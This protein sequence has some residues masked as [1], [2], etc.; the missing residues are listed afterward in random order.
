MLRFLLLFMCLLICTV[1]SAQSY[2]WQWAYGTYGMS[3][4]NDVL[5]HPSNGCYVVGDISDTLLYSGQPWVAQAALTYT[6][7]VLRCNWQG[8]AQW[9]IGASWPL[10]AVA[11][12]PNG[13]ARFWAYYEGSFHMGDSAATSPTHGGI[14][15]I[16]LDENGGITRWL[17]YPDLIDLYGASNA[18]VK[19]GFDDD[20]DFAVA[21]HYGDSVWFDGGSFYA[22][23]NATNRVFLANVGSDGTVAWARNAGRGQDLLQLEHHQDRTYVSVF[24]PDSIGTADSLLGFGNST[25]SVLDSSGHLR[26][27]IQDIGFPGLYNNPHFA[28]Y[29]NGDLLYELSYSLNGGMFTQSIAKYDI[30]G[31]EQWTSWPPISGQG[32]IQARKLIPTT[33]GFIMFGYYVADC[34]WDGVNGVN[35][36]YSSGPSVFVAGFDTI[37][38]IQW[39]GTRAHWVFDCRGDVNANGDIY[40]TG[41]VDSGGNFDPH[42]VGSNGYQFP[43][44]VAKLS[45]SPQAVEGIVE[46]RILLFPNPANDVISIAIPGSYGGGI[47]DVLDKRGRVCLSVQV[48]ANSTPLV[49]NVAQLSPGVYSVQQVN[50]GQKRMLGTFVK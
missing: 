36:P 42:S 16:D 17:N 39:A 8:V 24:L 34:N 40:C 5:A 48:V 44:Y 46:Q 31:V 26:W 23:P 9:L 25:V 32:S 37:G 38:Q 19:V 14:A 12:Q 21:V 47:I 50:A 45:S 11:T 28:I 20:G 30:N 29:P 27:R 1:L 43:T 2:G 35:L 18:K 4:P 41:F 7:A 22:I 15:V 10:H 3:R 33:D 49:L 13:H 6:S